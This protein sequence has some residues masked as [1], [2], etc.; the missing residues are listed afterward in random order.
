MNRGKRFQTLRQKSIG[1]GKRSS[2]P[3]SKKEVCRMLNYSA[4]A[5]ASLL[6]PL[7]HGAILKTAP[8][9]AQVIEELCRLLDKAVK[10]EMPENGCV[11]ESKKV[12]EIL[13]R[14][15]LALPF[16]LI[17]L[18]YPHS[19][20]SRLNPITNI[21]PRKRIA[22]CMDLK[23]DEKELIPQIFAKGLS[24]FRAHGCIAVIP[25]YY[26]DN[27]W[28]PSVF[29]S[30]IQKDEPG[31]DEIIIDTPHP[32]YKDAS[33]SNKVSVKVCPILPEAANRLIDNIGIDKAINNALADN[34]DEVVAVSSLMVALSCSNVS[35]V[36]V[37]AP[38]KLNKK[39]K[40]SGKLP[41]YDYRIV[42]VDTHDSVKKYP[43]SQPSGDSTRKSPREHLRRGHIRRLG[44]RR[45][46]VQSAIVGSGKRLKQTY[47]VK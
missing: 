12:V 13:D 2:S 35:T 11:V 36:L 45:I 40:K 14:D 5:I 32:E 10:F 7:K 31:P 16:P 34:N 38:V 22:L 21:A 20:F 24:N 28:L 30:L 8:L 39:R 47:I 37:P 26:I 29:A 18:E 3:K 17:V 9:M 23:G 44:D 42:V 4:D 19:D 41:L 1:V 25:I 27:M 43:M 46:W 33:R 6:N 15:I